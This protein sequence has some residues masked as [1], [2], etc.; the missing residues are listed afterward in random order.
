M[1]PFEFTV[2]GPPLSHQANRRN[3]IRWKETVRRAAER[4]WQEDYPP[5]VEMVNVVITNFYK[6]TS[7]DVDNIAKP[8]LDALIG[9]VYLDDTQVADS[10]VR[11]RSLDISF[12]QKGV[13]SLIAQKIYEGKEFVLVKIEIATD[14]DDIS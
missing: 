11:K 4:L 10:R 1:L 9:L 3:L 2:D 8:I 5:T 7:P 6:I 13:S 14:L 12:K